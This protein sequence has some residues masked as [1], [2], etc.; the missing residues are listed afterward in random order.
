VFSL[1]LLATT[2]TNASADG[3]KNDGHSKDPFSVLLASTTTV[4]VNLYK[5]VHP[6][7]YNHGFW[8][9][10]ETSRGWRMSTTIHAAVVVRTEAEARYSL[11]SAS[12]TTLDSPEY[13]YLLDRGCA[14]QP[15]LGVA[16]ETGMTLPIRIPTYIYTS[17]RATSHVSP[18]SNA[19]H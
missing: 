16:V 17:E 4:R 7:I 11:S 8:P 13:I 6:S 14:D 1:C 2:T 18:E 10:N 9:T 19:F 15:G 12:M 3:S 5:K